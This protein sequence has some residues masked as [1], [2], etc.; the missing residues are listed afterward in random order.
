MP[1]QDT[2]DTQDRQ[3]FGADLGV[4]GVLG[5]LVRRAQELW[6]AYE[7]VGTHLG[8]ARAARS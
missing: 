2:Q 6:S 4:L 5:V 3:D 7:A 1:G 8:A